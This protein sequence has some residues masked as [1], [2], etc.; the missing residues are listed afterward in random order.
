MGTGNKGKENPWKIKAVI[1]SKVIKLLNRSLLRQTSRA[2]SW[3]AKYYE[4]ST[5]LQEQRAEIK[6]QALTINALTDISIKGISRTPPQDV[7]LA[8]YKFPLSV[9]WL[10]IM[11]YMCGLSFRGVS[12]VWVFLRSFLGINFKIPSY[13]TVRIWV[14]KQGLYMLKKGG[15]IGGMGKKN[16]EKWALIVDESYSLGKSRLLLVLGIRLSSLK[17]GQCLTMSDVEPIEIQSGA[18]WK[19]DEVVAVLKKAVKK[20]E[21]SV[22]YVVSDRGASLV[23]AYK[24]HGLDHVPDWSH[25]IANILEGLYAQNDDFK[26]FNI[27]MSQFKKKR[28]QSEYS[29]Y[30]PPTLSVKMR[31]MNYIPFLEWANMLLKNFKKLPLGIIEE[32]AFLKMQKPFIAEMTDLFFTG[33]KIGVLLKK[34]GIDLTT[35]EEVRLIKEALIKKYPKNTRVIAFSEGIDAYFAQTMPIYENFAQK[36][37]KMPLVFNGLIASSEIIESIFGKF[38]HRCLKDPKRGFSAIALIIPLLCRNFS[39]FDVFKAMFSIHAKDLCL[40][41]KNNLTKKGYKSFRNIFNKK[42]KKGTR[43]ENAV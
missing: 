11:L 35:E 18:T 43:F 3:R 19:E 39:P 41:E 21:G 14:L 2:E 8:G 38:K 20:V 17:K 32:L 13:G 36:N 23:S 34:Q 31:F 27:K 9:M 33:D 7:V 26:E 5:V 40:W 25:Y 29:Q 28:K 42:T 1:R 4:Q 15:K 22:A 10:S 12:S 24:K 37:E 16:K 30:S 6:K